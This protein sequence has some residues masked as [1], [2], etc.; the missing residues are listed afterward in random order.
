MNKKD[1]NIDGF[2]HILYQHQSISNDQMQQKSEDF[3]DWMDQRRSIR[4][5]SDENDE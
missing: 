3:Y 4:E 1:I 5:F 2:R